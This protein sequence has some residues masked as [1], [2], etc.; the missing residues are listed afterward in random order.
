M[1]DVNLLLGLPI[2]IKLKEGTYRKDFE[3]L[4]LQNYKLKDFLT[5]EVGYEKYGYW[6]S[7]ITTRPKDIADILW[8]QYNTY[9]KEMNDWVFVMSYCYDFQNRV[10]RPDNDLFEALRFMLGYDYDFVVVEDLKALKS[11]KNPEDIYYLNVY[12]SNSKWVAKIDKDNFEIITEKVKEINYIKPTELSKWNYAYEKHE[13]R[14]LKYYY[15]KRNSKVGKP[16]Y[17][18]SLETVLRFL[19]LE[20]G[21]DYDKWLNESLY[22]IYSCYN[23]KSSTFQSLALHIG[24]YGGNV[25]VDSNIKN[26]L[27]F[28]V[29]HNA[30]QVE[31][32]ARGNNL[33]GIQIEK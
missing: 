27:I 22:E 26:S 14:A 31:N 3:G 17:L 32:L 10:E 18:F 1:V 6:C 2:P 15:D 4:F 13:K 19:R 5:P 9:Y 23:M 7:I 16:S 8:V 24:L 30:E 33:D 21:I 11:G 12:D 20:T 25:K 29:V 28:G